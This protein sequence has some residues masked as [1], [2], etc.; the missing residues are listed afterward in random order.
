MTKVGEIAVFVHRA[1]KGKRAKTSPKVDDGG[2]FEQFDHEIP[3][4]ALKGEAKY[5]GT[6]YVRLANTRAARLNKS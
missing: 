3:E 4:K 5:H 1:S 6:W 2:L